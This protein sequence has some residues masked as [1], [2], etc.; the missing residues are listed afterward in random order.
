MQVEEDCGCE[1]LIDG[2][3]AGGKLSWPG[4]LV[5][6]INRVLSSSCPFAIIRL[7]SLAGALRRP[8][9]H[10]LD[11]GCIVVAIAQPVCRRR[12][13]VGEVEQHLIGMWTRRRRPRRDGRR[14]E[15]M[16]T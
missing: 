10:W 16:A 14:A 15:A 7:L 12:R 3:E 8:G 1:N 6:A 5:V 9:Q 13:R 11:A 4:G 2:I